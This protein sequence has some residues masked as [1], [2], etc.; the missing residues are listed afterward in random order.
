M[1]NKEPIK[2]SIDFAYVNGIAIGVYSENAVVTLKIAKEAVTKRKLISNNKLSP[3]LIDGRYVKEVKKEARDYFSSD[4]GEEL[5]SAVALLINS[6]FTST[7]ANFLTKFSF[8]KNEVPI[9]V[10][11]DKSE[12]VEWLKT[13][14]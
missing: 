5:L 4:E 11:S 3:M 7:I 8:K 2:G 12:A 13:F 6:A 1:K 9:K 10:F 14:L